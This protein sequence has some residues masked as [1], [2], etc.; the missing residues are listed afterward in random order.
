MHVIQR[1]WIA[2]ATVL[3]GLALPTGAAIAGGPLLVANDGSPN[4]W[5]TSQAIPYRTDNGPLSA[6]VTE[7]Q[8][9][10]RVVAMFNVWQNVTTSNIAYTRAGAISATG[11]F[12]GGDVDTV[13]EYN[14]VV[15][16]CNT[17]TRPIAPS[18]TC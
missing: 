17:A 2:L 3:A 4:V 1:K 14:A 18:K 10:A 12:A 8:A 6:A 5:D 16:S 7:A 9:Q 13:A 15:D 11:A